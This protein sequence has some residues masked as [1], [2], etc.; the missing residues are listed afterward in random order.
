MRTRI[1]AFAL[2]GAVPAFSLAVFPDNGPDTHFTSVGTYAGASAVAIDPFWVLT[3]R[4]IDG[5]NFSTPELGTFN[6][7]E[8]HA[9][10]DSDLRLL[11]V[12]H[13]IS[14]Y[15]R[16]STLDMTNQEVSLVGFGGTGVTSANGWTITGND[17]HRHSAVNMVEGMDQ[18]SFDPSGNPNWSAWFYEL[19][20]PGAGNGLYGS[21]GW[22]PGEGGIFAGDSG[23]G[24][25]NTL[26]G[27]DY[28]VAT[29]SAIDDALPGGTLTDYFQRGYGT[30][31]NDPLNV[32]WIT[33]FVPNAF[34]TPVP[35]PASMAAL[36]L[37]ALA[38]VRR[39]RRK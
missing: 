14:N 33:S 12:D 28:L 35:E 32:S 31:L 2:V 11:K 16:I 10:P 23:G 25:F 3:A 8:D 17:G 37:G 26:G 21:N 7:L 39:R 27:V 5:G 24:W 38:L 22:I 20:K 13:A 30:R 9:S 18:I 29:N 19:D 36:G 34:V 1:L 15:T 6:V 4:H